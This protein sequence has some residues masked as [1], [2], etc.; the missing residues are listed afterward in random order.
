MS[1][2]T[3]GESEI[4][5]D[6]SQHLCILS[7]CTTYGGQHHVHMSVISL[8]KLSIPFF[9][10]IAVGFV[11]SSTNSFAV[12]ASR[13]FNGDLVSEHEAELPTYLL[14]IQILES[15]RHDDG[16]YQ[17]TS[18]EIEAEER[19]DG[20]SWTVGKANPTIS[21]AFASPYVSGTGDVRP[22]F[23]RWTDD[24]TES[25]AFVSNCHIRLE[26]GAGEAVAE[27]RRSSAQGFVRPAS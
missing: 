18:R 14:S 3:V 10:N 22:A 25:H 11:E 16:R 13:S 23:E 19:R 21:G 26:E 12:L 5:C 7:A 6:L 24:V 27:S 9:G 1:T 8:R 15:T 17:Y 2:K 4:V 20:A